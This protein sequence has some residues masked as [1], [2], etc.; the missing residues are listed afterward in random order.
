VVPSG[1][2]DRCANSRWLAVLSSRRGKLFRHT[3]LATAKNREK[4]Q[5]VD[6]LEEFGAK[7]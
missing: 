2:S 1:S 3:V 6:L 5:L 7:E 4:Q